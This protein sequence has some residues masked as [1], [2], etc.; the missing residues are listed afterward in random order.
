M[1]IRWQHTRATR[2][3]G[4]EVMNY[5][6]LAKKVVKLDLKP[7]EAFTQMGPTSLNGYVVIPENFPLDYYDDI[8]DEL[9]QGPFGGLTFGGYF[10]EIDKNLTP[11]YLDNHPFFK[12]SEY[13]D[14]EL[15]WIEIIKSLSVRVIG[16]DDNHI[17]TNEMGAQEG[18]LYL[19]TQLKNIFVKEDN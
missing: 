12:K 18:S 9:D 8:Y 19:S 17:W 11:V 5:E 6:E 16:F 4:G 15:A 3:V 10:T 13:S 2:I 1:D 14:E 7:F